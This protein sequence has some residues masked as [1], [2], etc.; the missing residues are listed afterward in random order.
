MQFAAP[1]LERTK[2]WS[3]AA[4]WWRLLAK[5][6]YRC[7]RLITLLAAFLRLPRWNLLVGIQNK[8]F[9]LSSHILKGTSDSAGDPGQSS[10]AAKR[11]QREQQYIF[12]Y[13]LARLS[14]SNRRKCFPAFRINRREC[15]EVHLVGQER[16]NITLRIL[17][18]DHSGTHR[19]TLSRRI[20]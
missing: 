13:P 4:S 5:S 3:P 6:A 7:C 1:T 12:D 16:N 17:W 10:N 2:G 8:S 15:F 11:D 18:Y 14:L 19:S 9:Q 20:A